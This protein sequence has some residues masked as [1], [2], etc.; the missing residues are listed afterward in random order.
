MNWRNKILQSIFTVFTGISIVACNNNNRI[1]NGKHDNVKGK[2]EDEMLLYAVKEKKEN[3]K[4]VKQAIKDG[5]NIYAWDKYL[6]TPLMY[7]ALNGHINIV[8]FLLKKGV[9][10]N[11]KNECGSTALMWAAL[12]GHTNIVNLL[13]DKGANVNIK[14][15]CGDTALKLATYNGYQDTVAVL[16]QRGAQ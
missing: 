8:E 10:I 5:A 11:H 1:S 12:N 9:N 2:K 6:N 4:G 16:V 7:A 13:L 15:T 3:L 14:N